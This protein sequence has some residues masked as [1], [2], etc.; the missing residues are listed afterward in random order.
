ME[1]IRLQSPCWCSVHDW[2]IR[3][4]IPSVCHLKLTI[5]GRHDANPPHHSPLKLAPQWIIGRG[6]CL[7]SNTV[8]R[9]L[10]RL[11]ITDKVCGFEIPNLWARAEGVTF[12]SAAASFATFPRKMQDLAG[13]EAA[14]LFIRHTR[15][16]S[17]YM[18]RKC[19]FAN[20]NTC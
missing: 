4:L 6:F 15:S 19:H 5:Q 7:W 11:H 2:G 10:P 14:G 1:F 17:A 9:C 13:E 20:V 18:L 8:H 12:N 3:H 16:A